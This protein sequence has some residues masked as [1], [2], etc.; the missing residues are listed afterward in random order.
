VRPDALE[1]ETYAVD[2][3]DV[4]LEDDSETSS[5]VTPEGRTVSACSSGPFVSGF[6]ALGFDALGLDALG[7][8]ALAT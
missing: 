1:I 7:L 5:W 6:D 3:F 2:G 4:G 8:D